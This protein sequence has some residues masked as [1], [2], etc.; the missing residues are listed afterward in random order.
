MAKVSVN[1]QPLSVLWTRPWRLDISSAVHAGENKIEIEVANLWVNRL[2]GD[3][4]KPYDGVTDGQWPQWLVGKAP[5]TSGRI[6]YATY[7]GYQATSP[8]QPSG[9]IGKATLYVK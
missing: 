7:V 5:R 4:Q 1:D 2:V 9:L 3:E 8:L 6:S